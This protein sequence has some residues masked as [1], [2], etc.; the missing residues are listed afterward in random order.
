MAPTAPGGPLLGLWAPHRRLRLVAGH[1]ADTCRFFHIGLP[2]APPAG[3]VCTVCGEA[4]VIRAPVVS[5]PSL[6][7]TRG[8]AVI[9]GPLLAIG[10]GP[11]S[12]SNASA[13]VDARRGRPSL[14]S[15]PSR[16]AAPQR[17]ALLYF[18]GVRALPQ[19]RAAPK[20]GGPNVGWPRH[21]TS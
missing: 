13:S 1:I 7:G 16:G 10:P 12:A 3:V 8:C 20:P 6:V 21:R 14:S 17:A 5:A 2:A 4:P 18:R 11:I 15:P 19:S 9:A